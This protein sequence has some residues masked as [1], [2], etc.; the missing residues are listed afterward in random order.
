MLCI[1]AARPEN[2]RDRVLRSTETQG[3]IEGNDDGKHKKAQRT[4]PPNPPRVTV[5][6]KGLNGLPATIHLAAVPWVLDEPYCSPLGYRAWARQEWYLSR[7]TLFF[8]RGG[9]S[10]KC[11]LDQFNER[12]RY[13]DMH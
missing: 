12:E 10:W 3:N 7:R 6:T 13:Y 11:R 1:E 2:V 8:T 5:L 4:S 9:I